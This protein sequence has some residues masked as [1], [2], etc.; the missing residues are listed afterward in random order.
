MTTQTITQS[1]TRDEAFYLER[2]KRAI[3][4]GNYTNGRIVNQDLHCELY[5][6]FAICHW[7]QERGLPN[8]NTSTNY[9]AFVW[10]IGGMYDQLTDLNWVSQGVVTWGY[11]ADNLEKSL[12]KV[13]KRL[14]MFALMYPRRQELQALSITRVP[15]I[16][17]D[18][19]SVFNAKVNDVVA[20]RAFGRSRAGIVVA[21]QGSRFVV[22]YMTPS[23]GQ[24]IHYKVLPLNFLFPKG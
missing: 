2:F 20:I 17:H 1:V 19:T 22:A 8:G 11:G 12:K 5:K 15:S 21:T 6:G 13:R 18:S 24:D 4:H 14:D 16:R 23:N 7:K 9:S 10:E 3:A